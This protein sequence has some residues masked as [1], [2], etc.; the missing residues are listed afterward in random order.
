[1]AAL[2]SISQVIMTVKKSV[3]NCDLDHSLDQ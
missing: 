1:V 2:S 3:Q